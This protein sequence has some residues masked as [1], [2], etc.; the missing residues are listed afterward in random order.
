MKYR[1]Q[2]PY[3]TPAGF[4]DEYAEYYFD[5]ISVPALKV[6]LTAGQ[7]LANIPLVIANSQTGTFSQEFHLRG[8]QIGLLSGSDNV[9]PFGIRLR[10]AVG[11]YL[12]ND[13]V[14]VAF[15]EGLNNSAATHGA[16]PGVV[17]EPELVFPTGGIFLIDLANLSTLTAS[18]NPFPITLKGV[19][20]YAL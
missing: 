19:H 17:F 8:M 4:R 5:E 7:I 16:L 2:F 20:R 13:F 10:D 6:N 3:Q 14:P 11:N 18:V 9:L 12:S 15:F 1:A